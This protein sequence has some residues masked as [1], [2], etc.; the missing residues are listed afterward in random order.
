MLRVGLATQPRPTPFAGSIPIFWLGQLYDALLSLLRSHSGTPALKTEDFRVTRPA[1]WI[2]R[3]RFSL[4]A[5]ILQGFCRE[6]CRGFL[7]GFSVL[8]LKGR[9]APKKSIE[10]IHTKIHD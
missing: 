9:K 4:H 3:C 6:F 2:L 5:W 8:R 10:K 1:E 7:C